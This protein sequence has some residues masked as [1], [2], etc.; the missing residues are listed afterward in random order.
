[1]HTAD[2]NAGFHF[3]VSRAILNLGLSKGKIKINVAHPNDD[4]NC[5]DGT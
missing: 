3:E 5:Y 1:M 2:E 4:R